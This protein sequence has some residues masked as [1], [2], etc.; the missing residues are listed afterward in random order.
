ML[1]KLNLEK[2]GSGDV[3]L[4]T[5]RMSP[6]RTGGNHPMDFSVQP[7]QLSLAILDNQPLMK[8]DIARLDKSIREMPVTKNKVTSYPF[9]NFKGVM[10]PKGRDQLFGIGKVGTSAGNLRKA[11]MNR[12]AIKQNQKAF[13]FNIEDVDMA[14]TDPALRGVPYGYMGNAIIKAPDEGIKILKVTS[15]YI[16]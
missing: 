8:A 12:M 14:L 13:H 1:R 3:F 5:R 2:G 15:I 9:K 6:Y 10:S 4:M 11:F 16:K 7:T